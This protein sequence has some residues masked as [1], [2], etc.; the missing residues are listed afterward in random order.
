M[1]G[2]RSWGGD[3]R[4]AVGVTAVEARPLLAALPPAERSEGLHSARASAHSAHDFIFIPALC[5]ASCLHALG[6]TVPQTPCPHP[7]PSWTRPLWGSGTTTHPELLRVTECDGRSLHCP[8]LAW[9]SCLLSEQPL[10][11]A[12]LQNSLSV[13]HPQSRVLKRIPKAPQSCRDKRD[14]GSLLTDRPRR[15]KR[16]FPG[17]VRGDRAQ[18]AC[19]I[20]TPRRPPGVPTMRADRPHFHSLSSSLSRCFC[21]PCSRSRAGQSARQA[22][23]PL[24]LVRRP[25]CEHH[26]PLLLEDVQGQPLPAHDGLSGDLG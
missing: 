1:V 4:A 17:A 13:F 19:A 12:T 25:R 16:W 21:P 23:E 22:R 8:P 5:H 14:S 18:P 9:R 2:W 7:S 11:L 15:A 24:C 10:G 6:T 20:P 3:V 26:G